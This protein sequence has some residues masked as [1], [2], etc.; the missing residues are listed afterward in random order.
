MSAHE[1]ATDQRQAVAD[2][3]QSLVDKN[4]TRGTSG[5]V[6]MRSADGMLITPTGMS[7]DQLLAE[8]IVAMSLDGQVADDQLTPSSEWQMHADV[9]R[10]KT[11]VAAI[12]HCH[13]PYATI[14]ACAGRPIPSLHYM[15]AAADSYGIPL[16]DYAIF[17]SKQL[18][19]CN[20]DALSGS[21]AC[22]LANHGQLAT[23]KNLQEALKL[24]DLVEE[25]AHCYWGTL[26][27][28]GPQL[29]DNTQME[30]VQQAFVTYGQQ[31][32]S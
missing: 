11:E 25:L 27:I 15:V 9:Y 23:G 18:S 21:K 31:K 29:L 7:P 3:L 4:L 13:S 14:L 10:E 12:V 32:P 6:S 16:A 5:N 17:G 24:A 2:T 20:L 1:T 26:C 28:G 19:R 8:H 30:A 22:L